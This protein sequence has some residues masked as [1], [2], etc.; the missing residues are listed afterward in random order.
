MCSK[1]IIHAMV[2]SEVEEDGGKERS[3]DVRSCLF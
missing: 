1:K 3:V 2:V